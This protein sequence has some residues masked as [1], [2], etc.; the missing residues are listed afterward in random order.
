M[1]RLLACMLPLL[2]LVSVASPAQVV[3]HRSG[4]VPNQYLV[5]FTGGAAS[6]SR[7]HQNAM[8]QA[9][10][11]LQ[12][13]VVRLQRDLSDT[14]LQVLRQLWIRNAV[15]IRISGLYLQRLRRLEYVA[16]VEADARLRAEPLGTIQLPLSGQAVQDYL[17]LI[18][19]DTLWTEG[20]Q[21][22]GVVV[23]VL[24]TGVDLRHE[25]LKTRWRG[26]SNSWYD[27]FGELATPDD[28]DPRDNGHGT[29]VT[30]LILGGNTATGA[31]FGAAPRAEWIAARIFNK[32]RSSSISTLIA[33]L[34]WVADPDGDPST[35]DYPDIVNNSWGLTGTEGACVNPFSAE[36]NALKA[37]GIDVVFAIG[38]VGPSASGKPT[39]LTPSFDPGVISVGAV[40]TSGNSIWYFSSRGPDQCGN[41]TI[42]FLVA[43]GEN[44]TAASQTLGLIPGNTSDFNGTSFAAPLVSGVMAL[45]RSR[46]QLDRNQLRDALASSAVDLGTPGVDADYGHGRVQASAAA[47]HLLSMTPPPTTQAVEVSFST[48]EYVV[49]E[50]DGSVEVTVLRSGDLSQAVSVLLTSQDSTA[51]R[52]S[53]YTADPVTLDFLAGEHRKTVM[54][55][56]LEDAL[57][58]GDERF[59]LYLTGNQNVNIG[60]R[61]QK[62]VVIKDNDTATS[63][64]EKIGGSALDAGF[65]LILGLL[66]LFRRRQP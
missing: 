53:D 42:P 56:V 31:Y 47:S 7:D 41:A 15:V 20:Y 35:D 14:D 3:M 11:Q 21:G 52:G 8:R 23:A 59:R 5:S 58:E 49:S 63:S 29:A 30:S 2:W 62:W 9:R 55:P 10:E 65:L 40:D 66:V 1:V 48:A 34:Q 13:R 45:L 18:D 26:G 50:G 51:T 38:N 19:L 24:D 44:L 33:A 32:Q 25:D 61:N 16:R 28:T 54:I 46:F 22:Q 43:P 37:L 36:L 17:D 4:T 60:A 27:P 39:Y 12:S 6:L 64:P 57:E